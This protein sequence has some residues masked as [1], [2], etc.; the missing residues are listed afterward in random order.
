MDNKLISI[1]AFVG[2]KVIFLDQ[3]EGH[4][5]RYPLKIIPDRI[6]ISGEVTIILVCVTPELQYTRR[7]CPLGASLISERYF[8]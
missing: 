8:R 6:R 1:L 4:D 2:H 7:Y 5:V 3:A